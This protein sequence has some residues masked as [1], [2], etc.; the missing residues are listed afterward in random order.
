M[1]FPTGPARNAVVVPVSALR[2][3]PGGD[4]VFVLAA[5]STGALRAAARSVVAGDVV[6]DEV[7]IREGVAAGEQVATSGSFKLRDGARV[8][9][10]PAG[11][12]VAVRAR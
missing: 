10:Q 2:K 1:D 3:G 12:S 7:V 4:Q 11:E 6:D 8:H 9:L 5:D